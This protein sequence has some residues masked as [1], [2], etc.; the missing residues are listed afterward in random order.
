MNDEIVRDVVPL[1]QVNKSLLKLALPIR[2]SP[3]ARLL[4]FLHHRLLFS[5]DELTLP[6][7]ESHLQG[8]WVKAVMKALLRSASIHPEFGEFRDSLRAELSQLSDQ[9]PHTVIWSECDPVKWD[10]L[11][12]YNWVTV[13]AD[14]TKTVLQWAQMTGNRPYEPTEY[15]TLYTILPG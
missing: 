2:K 5:G 14:I 10:D 9:F 12:S 1:V 3:G 4:Q 15:F 6:P 13:N 7:P 8:S 11:L